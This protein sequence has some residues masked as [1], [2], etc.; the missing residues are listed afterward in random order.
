MAYYT[1]RADLFDAAIMAKGKDRVVQEMKKIKIKGS[2]ATANEKNLL[3]I[4]ELCHEMY[5]RG[6]EFGS[7]SLYKSHPYKFSKEDGKIIPPLNAFAGVG[8]NAAEA[9]A[10]A[11]EDGDF[12]SKEDLKAR[13][14]ITKTVVEVLAENG[15]LDDLPDSSQISF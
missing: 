12:M 7:V 15:V 5:E 6:I 2:S 11:R 9:I 10:K 14:G 13:A 3:T 4:L 8:T 1:V